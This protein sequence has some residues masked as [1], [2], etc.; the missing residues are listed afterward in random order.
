MAVSAVACSDP[1]GD[2]SPIEA[3]GEPGGT[4]GEPTTSESAT[5]PAVVGREFDCDRAEESTPA[6][7]RVQRL[8]MLEY[9][10]AVRDLLGVDVA[11]AQVE[12][13][14]GPA[15]D[16]EFDNTPSGATREHVDAFA[17][18]AE[19]V[20][21][22]VDVTRLVQQFGNGCDDASCAREMVLGLGVALLRAPLEAVERDSLLA[23]FNAAQEQGGTFEQSVRLLVEALLQSPR[24]L[25]RMEQEQGDGQARFVQGMELASRLSFA[26]WGSAPDE[27]LRDLALAR[28]LDDSTIFLQEVERMLA[29]ER[30]VEHGLAFFDD[31]FDLRRMEQSALFV[32]N[33]AGFDSK[34]L[35]AMRQEARDLFRYVLEERLPVAAVHNLKRAQLSDDLA[36]HYGLEPLSGAAYDLSSVPER[37]GLL[38]LG[39]LASAGG[40]PPSTVQRGLFAWEQLLCGSIPDPP[41]DPAISGSTS[42]SLE[43]PL[44]ASRERVESSACGA[45]HQLFEPLAWGLYPYDA[46]GVYQAQDAE[47]N[48]TSLDGWFTAPGEARVDFSSPG[49]LLDALARSSRVRDCALLK[50]HEY[51]HK[52]APFVHDACSLDAARDALQGGKGTYQDLLRAVVLAP[53]FSQ[54]RTQDVGEQP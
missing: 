53:N 39:A 4:G 17:A 2:A 27:Q 26:I 49:E 11:A 28:E 32:E 35:G 34:L 29:D 47:G 20:A 54:L 38:T 25:Y 41:D 30:A 48:S 31:W 24:F 44:L 1:R 46:V 5:R 22:S 10:N 7:T 14:D 50:L 18:L 23:V 19:Y 40:V 8:T 45:C 16:R 37:G 21:Q 12:L 9:A 42:A 51:V 33:V 52:S 43:T 15:T 36:V 6:P 13:P 3:P